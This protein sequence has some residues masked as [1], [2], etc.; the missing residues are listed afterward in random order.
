M[1]DNV[2][3]ER[4]ARWY[5][6]GLCEQGHHGLV[7]CALG[8]ACWKTYLSR[9]EMDMYKDCAYTALADGLSNVDE[10]FKL[11]VLEAQFA[12][13]KRTGFPPE[14]MFSNRHNTATCYSKLGRHEDALQIYRECYDSEKA[15]TGLTETVLTTASCVASNFLDTK[16]FKSARSFAYDHIDD[17]Q[18][19]LGKNHRIT[20][21]LRETYANAI[22]LDAQSS[23]KQLAEAVEVLGRLARMR[24]QVFGAHH[25][26]TIRVQKTLERAQETLASRQK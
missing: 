18:R 5:R 9:P 3:I 2:K 16:N 7:Y 12:A 10:A 4:W 17:S 24:Q 15:L 23:L 26:C 14:H 11:Q 25:P 21:I 20:L 19:I 13:A 22:T 1:G 8:W 6:C